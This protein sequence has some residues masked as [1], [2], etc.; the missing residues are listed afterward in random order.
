M[1]EQDNV[2]IDV[3]IDDENNEEGAEEVKVYKPKNV[4]SFKGVPSLCWGFFH[5]REDKQK[6]IPDKKKVFCDLCQAELAYHSSTS[7]LIRHLNTSHKEKYDE[8]KKSAEEITDK[9]TSNPITNYTTAQLG[10]NKKSK[11]P[12]SSPKYIK[13]VELI[14][15]WFCQDSRPTNIVDDQGFFDLMEFCCPEFDIPSRTTVQNYI[16]KDYQREKSKIVK[17]LESVE[18]CAVTSDGGTSSNAV[19]FLDTNV[20]FVT[21]NFELKSYTLSVKENKEKHTAANYR[22]KVDEVL[23]DFGVKEKVVL[24]TTDNEN[25]M[26][27]AFKKDE[28]NGCLCHDLHNTVTHGFDEVPAA[29][30]CVEKCRK[31]ATYHNK[32]YAGRYALETAQKE[33]NIDQ[34]PLHQDVATRWGSTKGCTGSLLD[35][36]KAGADSGEEFK[37]MKAVN[38][39]LTSVN[40]KKEKLNKLLLSSSDMM[41]IKHIHVFLTSLDIYSTTLGGN[42]FV[43]SSIVLPIVK[44]IQSHLKPSDND[45]LYICQLKQKMFDDFKSRTL[46]DLNWPILTKACFLD[47]RFKKLKVLPS[48]VDRGNIKRIIESEMR[49]TSDAPT[50]TN[51]SSTSGENPNSKKRKLALDFSESED[52]ED[53]EE[54]IDQVTLELENYMKEPVLDR[55]LDALDWWRVN[56]AKYPVM[57]RLV[58]KYFCIPA[59]SVEA[60]RTFS[61]LGNLLSKRRL[62]MTGENVDKQLFLRDKYRKQ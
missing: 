15:K 5:F 4:L 44:S 32:S 48:H 23:D 49:A 14:A 33:A 58:K 7:S 47:P 42:S 31:I 62:S 20:H 43:T 41:K 50:S 1:E 19:S 59:T 22:K 9:E 37:N 35:K 45:P 10:P 57:A 8:A 27:A 29:K 24:F 28:R 26:K 39:A 51:V 55:D 17:E 38:K 54:S 52:D 11:W 61:S 12:K 25:K 56:C 6:K 2:P 60:E 3:D 18:F 30:D 34:R 16:N 21:D 40:M 13:A 36:P 53:D 46:E